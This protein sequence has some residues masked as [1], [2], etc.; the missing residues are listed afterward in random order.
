M[1]K[2]DYLQEVE[3]I[4]GELREYYRYLHQHPELPEEERNTQKWILEKLKSWGVTCRPCADTGVYAIIKS[5]KEGKTIAFRGDMDALPVKE[6]TGLPFSSVND[7]VMHAC[8]HDAHMAVLLGTIKVLKSYEEELSG[9]VVFLFQPAEEKLS[10]AKR[11]LE[12]SV[13]DNPKVDLVAAFHV[14][15]RAAG[16]IA[17]VTGPVMAGA[18]IFRIDVKGK[19]GHGGVPHKAVSPIP[20]LA[21]MI[22]MIERIPSMLLSPYEPAVVNVCHL[23]SGHRFN[24]IPETGFLEGTIRSFDLET[25]KVIINQLEKNAKTVAISY[26]VEG[27]CT[28]ELGCLPTINDNEATKWAAEVLRSKL[29]EATIITEADPATF[30]E[31]FSEFGQYAPTIYMGLGAWSE[32]EDKQY[33][34][35]NSRFQVDESALVLGVAAFCAMVE[36]FCCR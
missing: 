26:G 8:G 10:G 30:A 3:K 13:M 14:W 19:G 5:G 34:L 27:T 20:A 4:S 9:N 31:D 24:I 21:A 28:V 33:P 22:P 17:C 32:D 35:H 29:P 1:N 15:P 2:R 6:E 23:T 11:M 18:D 12:E 25:R 36:G 16:T 7:G